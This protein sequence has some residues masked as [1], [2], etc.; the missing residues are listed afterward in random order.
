MSITVAKEPQA[1]TPAE[2]DRKH[3]RLH[4]KVKKSGG[5]VFIEILD[6]ERSN[7]T[8]ISGDGGFV[9]AELGGS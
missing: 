4:A 7:I 6:A 2:R 9:G 3:A 1:M 5:Y 8:Y